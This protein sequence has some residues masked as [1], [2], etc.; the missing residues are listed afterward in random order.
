MLQL[1]LI[2]FGT[3]IQYAEA[4]FHR[5]IGKVER[6][7][8]MVQN[9]FL[10]FNLQLN[11]T[12]T[13][14]KDPRKIINILRTIT[15]HIQ[16]AINQRRPRIS[17]YSPNMLMF[18]TRVKDIS[19][20]EVSMA[21]LNELYKNQK[22]FGITKRQ[23]YEY[24][25]NLLTNLKKIYKQYKTDWQKYTWLSRQSY[26]K[27]YNITQNRLLRNMEQFMVNKEVLYFVGD[28]NIPNRK[29]LR[30]YTGP[31]K[32]TTKLSDGTVIITD[33]ETGNQKRVSIDRLKL[34]NTRE[35]DRYISKFKDS[36][37]E[38]YINELKDI[39]FN[40]EKP[41]NYNTKLDYRNRGKND[42]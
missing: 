18:G 28:K 19:N 15:P 23:D 32:I 6:I 8:R 25:R 39:L 3:D 36:Q 16:A 37:Y 24:V 33:E 31:W 7:N 9:S 35:Y 26:N 12:I 41:N 2:A 11:D 27:R 5:S 42:L 13:D 38:E 10:K 1:L 20:I 22:D 34:F 4:N 29:W 17:S 30:K 40:V 21:R 14:R